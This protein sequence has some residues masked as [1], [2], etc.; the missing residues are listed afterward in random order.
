MDPVAAPPVDLDCHDLPDA[1]SLQPG[2]RTRIR[3]WPGS[4]YPFLTG[5]LRV[6]GV[7]SGDTLAFHLH[8]LELDPVGR[9]GFA[10]TTNPWEPWGGV[11]RESADQE[12]AGRAEL[13]GD[14]AI[15][16]GHHVVPVVPMLG[17]L[18][19]V[20]PELIADPWDHGGNLDT[21]EFAP[22]STLYLYDDIGSGRFVIGDAHAAMGDGEISG[23]GIE[24]ASWCDLTVEVIPGTRPHRPIVRTSDVTVHLC[25]RFTEK[26]A[27][28]QAISDA[29]HHLGFTQQLGFEQ[30]NALLS[31]IGDLRVSSVVSHAPTYKLLVPSSWLGPIEDLLTV[32]KPLLPYTPR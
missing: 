15:L 8:A 30:A 28:A 23:Q 14:Q 1:A 7:S 29:V 20:R 25:S 31:L 4:D 9:Y 3:T 22:G 10:T 16:D 32:E 5:P 11:L 12:Y 13:R 27:Y 24:I 18:G 17:W 19:L 26:D 2:R 21:K 6:E